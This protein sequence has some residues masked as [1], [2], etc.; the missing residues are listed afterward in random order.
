MLPGVRQSI[1]LPMGIVKMDYWLY[2]LFTV[3][4]SGLWCVVLAWVGVVAGNDPE[5]MSGNLRH[6]TLWLV[7]ALAVLGMLYYFLVHRYIKG[8]PPKEV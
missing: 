3:I 6:V 8:G 1:G 4:G 5:L 2:A 7:G